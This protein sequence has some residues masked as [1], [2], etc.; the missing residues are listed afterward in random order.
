[1]VCTACKHCCTRCKTSDC[2]SAS[3]ESV[4]RDKDEAVASIPL[5]A[6]G[7]SFVS[8]GPT[9]SLW[10]RAAKLLAFCCTACTLKNSEYTII[11]RQLK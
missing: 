10:M 1:M 6:G 3:R 4:D 5:D 7:E 9:S 8:I 2:E 11:Q